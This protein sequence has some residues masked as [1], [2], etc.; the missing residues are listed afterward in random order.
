MA[1]E[2]AD[3]PRKCRKSHSQV[4]TETG[5]PI[6]SIGLVPKWSWL[7]P[8]RVS[9][10][11]NNRISEQKVVV[12]GKDPN[13]SGGGA[14]RLKLLVGKTSPGTERGGQLFPGRGVPSNKR[15]PSKRRNPIFALP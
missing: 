2:F 10:Q 15:T 12:N 1:A 13:S 7:S 8:W 3:Q 14:H 9:E 5:V 6:S 4:T 11:S